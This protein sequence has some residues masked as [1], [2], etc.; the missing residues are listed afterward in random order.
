MLLVQCGCAKASDGCMAKR[1]PPH[2]GRVGSLQMSGTSLQTPGTLG[3]HAERDPRSYVRWAYIKSISYCTLRYIRHT[4]LFASPLWGLT[5]FQ[6]LHG[7][8]LRISLSDACL[9]DAAFLF[10]CL[11]FLKYDGVRKQMTKMSLTGSWFWRDEEWLYQSLKSLK[12]IKAS[13]DLSLLSHPE[14]CRSLQCCGNLERMLQA[15]MRES[16]LVELTWASSHRVVVSGPGE[17]RRRASREQLLDYDS[18]WNRELA[19]PVLFPADIE[20]K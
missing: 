1:S 5:L 17:L 19:N 15:G 3:E 4:G 11:L 12:I 7:V 6:F 2:R 8:I 14:T 18:N 13:L 10:S 20:T 9:V 16:S